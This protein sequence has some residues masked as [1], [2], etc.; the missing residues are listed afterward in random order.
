APFRVGVINL[1]SGDTETDAMCDKIYGELTN[2][3]VTV[4]YDDKDD[5]AGGKFARMDLIG[6]PWQV[7]VGP[8]GLKDGIAEVKNR[9]TGEREK[10]PLDQVAARFMDQAPA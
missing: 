9:A 1:K 5:R 3:G 8:R 10:V 7:I 6:L 2:A 4:L